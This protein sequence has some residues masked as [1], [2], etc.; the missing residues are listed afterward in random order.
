M[1]EKKTDSYRGDP[2]YDPYSGLHFIR[3]SRTA[4]EE[5]KKLYSHVHMRDVELTTGLDKKNKEMLKDLIENGNY[6]SLVKYNDEGN[7]ECL[8][9]RIQGKVSDF[10]HFPH[11]HEMKVSYKTQAGFEFVKRHRTSIKDLYLFGN[12]LS[13]IPDLSGFG[14][15]LFLGLSS[16]NIKEFNWFGDLLELHR[17][18]LAN[19]QLGSLKGF[20]RLVGCPELYDI[21]LSDNQI[22]DLCGLEPFSRMENLK[23]LELARNKITELNITLGIPRLEVLGLAY[24]QIERIIAVKNLPKLRNLNLMGNKL[25]ALENLSN[26]PSLKYIS[27]DENQIKSIS[28]FRNLHNLP[29]LKEISVEQ[30]RIKSLLGLECLPD[31]LKITGFELSHFHFSPS[32]FKDFNLYLRSIG[33]KCSDS[34][35]IYKPPP[36]EAEF[37]I[38][39]YLT[40]RLERGD[41]NLYVGKAIFTHCKFLLLTIPKENLEYFGDVRS[42]DE[43]VEIFEADFEE[44]NIMPK[45]PKIT[46]FWGHASNLQ[47]WA[48]HNYDTRLLHRNLAFPLLKK[49]TELGDP[50]AKRVFKE[51]IAKRC[52]SGHPSVVEFLIEEEYLKY[53]SNEEIESL[54]LKIE[55][56]TLNGEV[57]CVNKGSL[58]LTKRDFSDIKEI[59][60]LDKITGLKKLKLS[61]RVCESKSGIL[62]I[63]KLEKF[64]NLIELDLSF[65]RIS[66]IK[67]LDNLTNLRVL[68]LRRNRISEI[69]GL[70]KL[71]NLENLSLEGNQIREIKGLTTLTKLKR[72]DLGY[73]RI[74]EIKGLE[75]LGKLEELLLHDNKIEE[76]NGILHLVNL[77][78]LSLENNLLKR[79]DIEYLKKLERIGVSLLKKFQIYK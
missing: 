34:G 74:S 45:I 75:N 67:G 13:N 49:L 11:L 2:L 68:N 35:V 41:I 42:I 46:Q 12:Q 26:L 37:K 28:H 31:S 52:S 39:E 19:N 48:E 38:N 71:I 50:M 3:M 25:T 9:L 47:A 14:N 24:N 79:D 65:N 54:N 8:S 7:V 21:N 23:R 69:N 63:K 66:E 56:V 33:W 30:N 16:N 40:L 78:R 17:L 55:Y 29:N 18:D 57:F 73:N 51:E 44:K 53:L 6:I 70:D 64:T 58:K 61:G 32:Q 15:L 36:P 60:G 5:R 1:T 59:K 20:E 62:E 77:K 43:A 76:I 10:V 72:F 22:S 27:V 4:E